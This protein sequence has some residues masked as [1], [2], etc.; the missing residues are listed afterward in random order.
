MRHFKNIGP[1]LLLAYICLTAGAYGADTQPTELRF[2]L[3]A[4]DKYL[5]SSIMKQHITQTVMGQQMKTTQDVT[6]DYIYDIRSVKDGITTIQVTF[7]K[8]KMDTDVGGL[9]QISFD[10]DNPD[11]ASS[12]LKAISG[13]IGKSFSMQVNSEGRVEKIEGLAE[14]IGSQE[15]A[16]SELLK[17]SFSDSS[18]AQSMNMM[19]NIYPGKPVNV[20]DQWTKSFSGVLAGMMQSDA[21]SAFTL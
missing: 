17:Q 13:L 5:F 8:I 3:R 15:G 4:G 11:A 18:M 12:E 1:V 21:T 14:L 19:T 16:Q 2:N 9:Q 6:T 10:S 7:D 20:G